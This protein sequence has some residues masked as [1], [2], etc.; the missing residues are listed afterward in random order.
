MGSCG[1]R[2]CR[3]RFAWRRRPATRMSIQLDQLNSR[4]G[5]PVSQQFVD[6]RTGDVVAADAVVKG[7][8]DR[9]RGLSS[10]S[11][12]ARSSRS[13]GAPPNIIEVAHFS[14]ARPG[15]PR[16]PRH[17]L[18][19]LPRWRARGRYARC[20]APGDAAQRPR[21]DRLC[22]A[23]RPRAHGADPAARRR[24]DAVD[25]AAAARCSNRPSSPSGR[26]AR[27]RRR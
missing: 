20:A 18:L 26:K 7:Y 2:W 3:A 12:T 10:R 6:S 9:E 19:R 5:N 1:C 16:P 22:P 24:A 25:A 11:P 13:A 21:R 14:A 8:Q 4:T 23:R 27:S 17:Q 15:R